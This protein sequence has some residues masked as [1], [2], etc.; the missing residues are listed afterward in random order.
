M[1][2]SRYLT[3]SNLMNRPS[4]DVPRPKLYHWMEGGDGITNFGPEKLKF[5]EKAIKECGNPDYYLEYYPFK[6]EL[7]SPSICSLHYRKARQLY[8]DTS[9]FFDVLDQIRKDFI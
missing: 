1:T 8:S 2:T 3:P 7:N 6:S 5:Y 4:R 9:E